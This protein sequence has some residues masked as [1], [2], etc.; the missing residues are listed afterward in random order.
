[1]QRCAPLLYILGMCENTELMERNTY[2]N[3]NHLYLYSIGFQIYVFRLP[4]PRSKKDIDRYLLGVL[5]SAVKKAL[6]KKMD[7]TGWTNHK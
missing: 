1:M 3:T 7:D 5:L 6:K 4:F 2:G